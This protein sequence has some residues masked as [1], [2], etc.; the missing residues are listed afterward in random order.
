MNYL[1]QGPLFFFFALFNQSTQIK[2]IQPKATCSPRPSQLASA[3][4]VFRH[5][6]LDGSRMWKGQLSLK[7]HYS[8]NPDKNQVSTKVNLV[9]LS[10]NLCHR[11]PV[12]LR[13]ISIDQKIIKTKIASVINAT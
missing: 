6:I 3:A 1:K 9:H 13:L 4:S 5:C 2:Q 7:K 10:D 12:N 8:Q 11:L